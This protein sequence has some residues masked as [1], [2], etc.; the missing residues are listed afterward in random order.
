MERD[1]TIPSWTK[2]DWS[3]AGELLVRNFERHL[4]HPKIGLCLADDASRL[5]VPA[6]SLPI[7]P[8]PAKRWN[9]GTVQCPIAHRTSSCEWARRLPSAA[10]NDTHAVKI[11]ETPGERGYFL[12]VIARNGMTKQSPQVRLL[13]IWERVLTRRRLLHSVRNDIC[14]RYSC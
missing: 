9:L 6:N 13:V 1:C 5:S 4:L 12:P 11:T 7:F 8:H 3:P 10:I 2:N 14:S